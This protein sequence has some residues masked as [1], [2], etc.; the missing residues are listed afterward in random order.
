M[1]SISLLSTIPFTRKNIFRTKYDDEHYVIRFDNFNTLISAVKNYDMIKAFFSE[2][3]PVDQKTTVEQI[4]ENS[5][6]NI[7]KYTNKVTREMIELF[8]EVFDKVL[9]IYSLLLKDI[10]VGMNFNEIRW[11]YFDVVLSE[12]INDSIWKMLIPCTRVRK[13]FKYEERILSFMKDILEYMMK[14]R[15]ELKTQHNMYKIHPG[16]SIHSDLSDENIK[17]IWETST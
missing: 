6:E 4:I 15:P 16:V 13:L 11:I 9:N 14:M 1:S 7:K 12:L 5:N 8:M 2:F 17:K 10:D 3:S